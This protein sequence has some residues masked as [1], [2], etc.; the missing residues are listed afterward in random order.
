MEYKVLLTLVCNGVNLENG[1]RYFISKRPDTLE[2]PTQELED[3]DVQG[4]LKKILTDNIDLHTNF[5]I[6]STK[7]TDVV[8]HDGCLYI[9]YS[10]LIP[11]DSTINGNYWLGAGLSGEHPLHE[12]IGKAQRASI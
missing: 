2:L 10:T 7:L 9:V 6:S 12:Q 4:S 11:L 3:Q 1:E 8:F 5:T